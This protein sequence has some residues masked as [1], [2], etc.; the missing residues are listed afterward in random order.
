MF[1]SL[2]RL[3]IKKSLRHDNFIVHLIQTNYLIPYDLLC[4]LFIII[5][6]LFT[7]HWVT[8][9][10]TAEI[11][12]TGQCPFCLKLLF[13]SGMQLT[14]DLRVNTFFALSR[15]NSFKPSIFLICSQV[16]VNICISSILFSNLQSIY[17][18]I[19]TK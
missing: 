2:R 8:Y 19:L 3:F 17:K 12:D 7:N 5:M 14:R 4:I 15:P 18:V 9:S 13:Y 11:L 6:S 16:Y 10:I 1:M